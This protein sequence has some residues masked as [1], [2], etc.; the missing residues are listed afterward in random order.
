MLRI[1]KVFMC[2]V[3]LFS[4]LI[5]CSSTNKIHDR[6]ISSL[7]TDDKI[8]IAGAAAV[9]AYAA[10]RIYK[11]NQERRRQAYYDAMEREEAI[12]E[13][14]RREAEERRA[15][16]MEQERLKKERDHLA[17][18]H[19]MFENENKFNELQNDLNL[20]IK[21]AQ[22]YN[23]QYICA[24]FCGAYEANRLNAQALVASGSSSEN[25][26]KKLSQ[27]C[28]KDEILFRVLDTKDYRLIPIDQYTVCFPNKFQMKNA[29]KGVSLPFGSISAKLT[30][31]KIIDNEKKPSSKFRHEAIGI[32]KDML[33]ELDGLSQKDALKKAK[34]AA[35]MPSISSAQIVE[36]S[37]GHVVLET[38][39]KTTRIEMN[40][41]P[42]GVFDTIETVVI[43]VKHSCSGKTIIE[44]FPLVISLKLALSQ[45]ALSQVTDSENLKDLF[46]EWTNYSENKGEEAAFC[47]KN[48]RK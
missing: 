25:A 33:E 4:F 14:E 29:F 17:F 15:F 20:E 9:G 1:S 11:N 34:E 36:S 37:P 12:A 13:S 43:D 48:M 8:I 32:I 3:V 18:L 5:S 21:K 31:F 46:I 30:D 19:L 39:D 47:K 28:S 38:K 41:T 10:Y 24:A 7:S 35:K 45:S 40:V 22:G 16:L 44:K 27:K 6:K 42:S 23:D 2:V 26:I